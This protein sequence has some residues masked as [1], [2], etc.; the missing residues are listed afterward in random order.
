MGKINDANTGVNERLQALRE[1]A[2]KKP[3]ALTFRGE[4]N[5][6]V[7]TSY[8][9]SP[10]TPA[11]AALRAREAGL[12]ACGSVDHDSVGA[13]R[14]MKAACAILGI[15][16]CAGFEVRVSW[17]DGPY[18]ARKINN[19][20]SPGLVYMTVQGIPD[21]N[22][23]QAGAFLAPVRAV[24]LER[25]RKMTV[26]ASALLREAGF[27]ELDFERDVVGRSQYNKADSVGSGGLTE[28]H[29][30]AAVADKI[31]EKLGRGSSVTETLETKFGVKVNAKIAGFLADPS[32]PHYEYD[33]L[34]V[35]KSQWLPRF[36][37]QPDKT[38]AVN[39]KKVVDFALAINAIPAYAYLGDV[40]ESPTG[41]KKAEKFE[42]DFLDGVFAELK[43]YGY[44][45]VT[46]MPPRNTRE[47]LRRVRMLAEQNDLLEISGVDINS[48][49]QKFNCPEVL[50]PEFSHLIGTTWTL[51]MH[52]RAAQVNPKMSF[53]SADNPLALLPVKKRAAAYAAAARELDLVGFSN[54]HKVVENLANGAYK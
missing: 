2:G 39:A 50:L 44:Q 21:G 13:A 31:T 7:H 29:L 54:L 5:N 47:Q 6:H 36:F 49:R 38:E 53:F 34:G 16:G 8:S 9:F 32:N 51:V 28:R 46:Y 43:R 3:S 52:E 27:A 23:P 41:D 45:A 1:A 24:R 42:D 15:G 35:L 30:L 14:E 40:A 12:E 19:P 48:S 20:D 22:L 18:A 26:A 10:Y 17:K 33:L 37:I 11:M 25:T 4:I